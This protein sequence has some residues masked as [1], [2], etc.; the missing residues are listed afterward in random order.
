MHAWRGILLVPGS[1]LLLTVL[2]APTARAAELTPG[3]LLVSV[4]VAYD[5]TLREYTPSGG[6]VQSVVVPYPVPPRPSSEILHDIVVTPGGQVAIYNGT[7]YPY[8]TRWTPSTGDW[9]HDTYAGWDTGGLAGYG[10]IAAWQNYVYATDMAGPPG[11]EGGLVRFNTADGTAARYIDY[12]DFIDVAT[13]FDGNIYALEP[14][15]RLVYE[16]DPETMAVERGFWLGAACRGLAVDAAGNIF[17]ASLDSSIYEFNSSGGIINSIDPNVGGLF[18][19]DVDA[20]GALVAGGL[21]GW[22]VVSDETL[23]SFS[24]FRATYYLDTFVSF[25][26]P[27]PEPASM[28]SAL[29]GLALLFPQRRR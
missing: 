9:T 10:G 15:E 6:L 1:G 13:G 18:D 26:T 27:V 5:S 17:G 14:N 23:Q 19:V 4:G 24:T 11:D 21:T 8:M 12:V 2:A 20:N 7:F 22:V 16:I 28:G 25:T 29:L 3:N